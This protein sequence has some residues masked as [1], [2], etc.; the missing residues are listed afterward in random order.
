MSRPPRPIR[1]TRSNMHL[2]P[3]LFVLSVL[4]VLASTQAKVLPPSYEDVD[5]LLVGSAEDIQRGFDILKDLER[6]C[7]GPLPLELKWRLAF[8]HCQL[9][10]V[11]GDQG[12]DNDREA[13]ARIALKYGEDAL[14]EDENDPD[15]AVWYAA[16]LGLVGEY[17]SVKE[18]IR[19]GFIFKEN[20][21]RAVQQRPRD[22]FLHYL[23]G[24]WQFGTSQ[25][26]WFE[27]K[28]AA[29]LFAAP[30]QGDLDQA[31]DEF[32]AAH[33][34]KPDWRANLLFLAKVF[35][36]KGDYATAIR[37]LDRAAELPVITAEDGRVSNEIDN[38][39]YKYSGYR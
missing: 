22:P 12:R 39:Q 1:H 19:G 14:K 26:S 34:E 4:S 3:L 30:P 23:L 28:A 20:I 10:E 16:S 29:A 7:P 8:A 11:R 15:V 5:A 6:N 33:R 25:L 27:R 35:I 37:H 38:L 18:R 2:T 17:S 24:R 36:E 9:A 13:L 31:L 21:D 32:T